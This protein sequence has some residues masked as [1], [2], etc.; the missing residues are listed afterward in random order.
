ML[1]A[2][3]NTLTYRWD[4]NP[5][6]G[7]GR[8]LNEWWRNTPNGLEQGFTLPERPGPANGQPLQIEMAVRGSLTPVQNG[9]AIAFLDDR[10]AAV[11]TYDKL[12]VTDAHDQIIPARL[13][14]T[15]LSLAGRGAG[16]E[17]W[18]RILVDDAQAAYPLTIDPLAQQA[19]LKASNTGGGRLVR[20]LGGRLRRHGGGRGAM[21][22]TAAPPG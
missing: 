4:A 19:Y 7:S 14:L 8:G 2:D 3:Q 20:L 12:L 17:G 21:A 18:L 13:T 10:G 11:L 1:Q 9:A 15:P 5:A 16:G 6:T 22:R